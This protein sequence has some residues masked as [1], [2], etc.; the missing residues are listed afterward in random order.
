MKP[1]PHT[2]HFVRPEKEVFR[3]PEL[4]EAPP[5]LGRLP[6]ALNARVPRLHRVPELVVN[7]T[8][9]WDILRD[10]LGRWIH[11]RDSL[12]GIGVFQEPLPIPDET[13]DVQLVVENAV[14]SPR[15][16]VNRAGAPQSTVWPADSFG[17]ERLCELLG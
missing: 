4:V 6:F 7:D 13:P 16:A 9:L 17:V 8:K 10:P 14:A 12:S 11:P 15:F 2:P 3:A 5:F 1:A